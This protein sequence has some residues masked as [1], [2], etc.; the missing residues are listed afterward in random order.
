MHEGK[1]L[2]RVYSGNIDIASSLKKIED[3]KRAKSRAELHR[4]IP[5][6]PLEEKQKQSPKRKRKILARSK[7]ATSTAA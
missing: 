1:I 2:S 7:K 6:N 5:I 3:L 4:G